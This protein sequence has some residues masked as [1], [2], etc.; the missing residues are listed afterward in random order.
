MSELQGHSEVKVGS[1]RGFGLVFAVVF[2]IISAWPLKDGGA[3]RLWA[4]VVAAAFVLLA[5]LRPHLLEPLNRLWFKLGM[6]LGAVVAPVVMSLVFFL[7]VTPT[8]W[9]VRAKGKDLLRL[10]I[11][12]TARSYW[13][14]RDEERNPM[15]SMKN[16]F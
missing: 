7:V 8:G 16:Q 4:L 10:R 11:D 2:T 6:G 15:G 12:R 14:E 1:N 13:I 5:L 3:P 9:L